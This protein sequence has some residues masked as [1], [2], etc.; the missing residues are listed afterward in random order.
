MTLLDPAWQPSQHITRNGLKYDISI[1]SFGSKFFKATWCCSE[2]SEKGVSAPIGET[3]EEAIRLAHIC[4]G[5][6][7]KLIHRVRL[8]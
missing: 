8:N 6:H 3:A 1:F 7:H 4:I 5:V 2:C